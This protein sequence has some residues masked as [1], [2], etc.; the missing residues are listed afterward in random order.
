ML[1]GSAGVGKTSI[2]RQLEAL[3]FATVAEAATASPPRRRVGTLGLGTRASFIDTVV[4]AQRRAHVDATTTGIQFHDRSPICSHAL[5]TWL[6]LPIS[7]DPL[8][9]LDRIADQLLY[10]KH[11]FFVRNLGLC[12]QSAAR[13]IGFADSLE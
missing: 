4:A 11:V 1:T 8:T 5:A 2:L 7:T 9:E 12:E 13:Q 6:E 10:D 3:G